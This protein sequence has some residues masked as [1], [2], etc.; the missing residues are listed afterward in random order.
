MLS[1]HSRVQSYK[2]LRIFA[3]SKPETYRKRHLMLIRFER[4]T[5][6]EAW[7]RELSPDLRLGFVPTMGA[8]H[9]GHLAL[10]ER[11][12][13]ECEQVAC[14][15]FV[16]PTQFNQ[17]QDL[18]HYPRTEEK[19]L[20]LLLEVGCHLLFLPTIE[21]IYPEGPE[22]APNPFVFG[23]LEKVMEGAHRPGHFR[24]VAQVVSRLLEIVQPHALYMGQKDYQQTLIVRSMLEQMN[25]PVQLVV[26]PTVREEDGLAMSSRN[27]RLSA[28][29]RA[30]APE[31]YRAMRAAATTFALRE[32]AGE[33]HKKNSSALRLPT[34]VGQIEDR[35][36]QELAALPD[37][38]PEYFCFARAADL[39]PLRDLPPEELPPPGEVVLCTAVWV[40]DV[41]LI[42]NL[43]VS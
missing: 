33:R 11:A 2:I 16:N 21:E 32:E 31:I 12:L 10:I 39:K 38:R 26:C 34:P 22:N 1:F 8:L 5:D 18:Q 15:I 9:H 27:L 23:E 13:K 19:D 17:A 35:Y 37:F 6:F 4:K 7:R 25:S 41:R 29:Q 40:G 20:Q 36:L 30:L 42:D 24:G 43:I 28:E 3:F 14:S